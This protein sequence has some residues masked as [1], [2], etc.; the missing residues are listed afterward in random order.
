MAEPSIG[1][2]VALHQGGRLEAIVLGWLM[3]SE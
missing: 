3:A 1:A 2:Q